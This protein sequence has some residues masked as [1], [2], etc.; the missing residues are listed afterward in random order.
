[1]SGSGFAAEHRSLAAAIRSRS[2]APYMSPA[3]AA[4]TEETIHRIY[5][6]CRFSNDPRALERILG[7]VRAPN[8]RIV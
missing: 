8:W 5:D 7:R 4:E 6:E 2:E 1:M 3:R